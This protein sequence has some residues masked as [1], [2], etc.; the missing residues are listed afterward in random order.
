M[1]PYGQ[2]LAAYSFVFCVAILY[3]VLFLSNTASSGTERTSV[4][5]ASCYVLK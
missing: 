5:H 2:I 1:S 4:V 3:V